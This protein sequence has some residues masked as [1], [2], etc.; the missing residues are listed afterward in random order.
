[1]G[2]DVGWPAALSDPASGWSRLFYAQKI[3]P[4]Q[5]KPA[6]EVLAQ[7][8]SPV[9]GAQLPIVI[10]MRYGAGQCIYVATDEIWRWRY[11][12][13]EALP[14]QFWM[15]MIRMLGRESLSNSGEPATLEANPRRV[16]VNQPARIELRLLDSQL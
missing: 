11:G 4:N 13:G 8:A 14:D 10:N 16:P 15:Q 6:A 5:L 9:N 12:R 3:E 7:T 2:D 1:I